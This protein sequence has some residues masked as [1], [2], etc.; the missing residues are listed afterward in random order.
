LRESDRWWNDVPS[1][2]EIDPA[3]TDDPYDAEAGRARYID[4]V[5]AGRDV[6]P[7]WEPVAA[8]R[9]YAQMFAALLRI[10]H[11]PAERRP[12]GSERLACRVPPGGA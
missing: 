6:V 11:D 3:S 10:A 2:G 9:R 8:W 4:D 7:R 5:F 1:A 12:S